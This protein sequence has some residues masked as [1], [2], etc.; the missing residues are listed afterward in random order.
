MFT[1]DSLPER[2][3]WRQACDL[4]QCSRAHFYRLVASGILPCASRT[5]KRRGIKVLRSDVE[6][7]LRTREQGEL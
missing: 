7:Y 1:L 4:I 3:N 6:N 5:G 2:L